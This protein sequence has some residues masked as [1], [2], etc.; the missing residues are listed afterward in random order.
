MKKIQFITMVSCFMLT[1]IVFAACNGSRS[2]NNANSTQ[3]EQPETL[4]QANGTEEANDQSTTPPTEQLHEEPHIRTLEEL[5]ATIIAAGE[6]WEDW[7]RIRGAFAHFGE[8]V[9]IPTDEYGSGMSY[10]ALLPASGLATLNDATEYLLQFYTESA[11]AAIYL[12]FREID[13]V[14]HFVDARYGTARPHWETATHTLMEQI[15]NRAVVETIVTAYDH[16]GS[17]GEMPT[18]TLTITMIDGK[19]D[20]GLGHWITD[21]NWGEPEHPVIFSEVFSAQHGET[22]LFIDRSE[23]VVIDSFDSIAVV[24]HA[25]L[26]E[27]H[28]D[29]EEIIIWA[30]Q[31]IYNASLIHLANDWDE[32]TEEMIYTLIDTYDMTDT[33]GYINPGEGLLIHNYSSLGTLPG[34]GI[35]FYDTNGERHFFAINRDNSDSPY[36]Y[37]MWNISHQ[38]RLE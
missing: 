12:P 36:W 16:R 18:A 29:G 23:N 22:T 20:S 30:N 1:M 5:S 17:G 3:N 27:P 31:P 19:I 38:M 32:T 11:L 26:W 9:F 24:D 10:S 2:D 33:H 34:S 37:M 6:F 15:D 21:W 28:S 7:W 8:S 35:S 4:N 25:R 13:G 14:L